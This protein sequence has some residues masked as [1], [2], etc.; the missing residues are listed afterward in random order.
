MFCSKCGKE[1]QEGQSFCPNCGAATTV[2]QTSKTVPVGNISSEVNIKHLKRCSGCGQ[3]YEKKRK[4]LPIILIVLGLVL[5]FLTLLLGIPFII[6]GLAIG[7]K[8]VCPHCG[9]S[10]NEISIRKREQKCF[11]KL[12]ASHNTNFYRQLHNLNSKYKMR[13]VCGILCVV[14]AFLPILSYAKEVSITYYIEGIVENEQSIKYL[15]VLYNVNNTI[16]IVCL[17]CWFIGLIFAMSNL[18]YSDSLQPLSRYGLLLLSGITV[19]LNLLMT[20]KTVLDELLYEICGSEWIR[21]LI[22]SGNAAIGGV[23]FWIITWNLLTVV[24]AFLVHQFNKSEW[25]HKNTMEGELS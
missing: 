11:G 21:E 24:L 13:R 10:M 20:E 3:V 17:L 15:D 12:N 9:Y 6:I 5:S 18:R 8:Q 14:S 16:G 4:G 23:R 7:K 25:L 19:V 22:D 2:S 1:V